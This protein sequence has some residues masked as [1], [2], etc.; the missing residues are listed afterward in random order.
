MKRPSIKRRIIHA[1]TISVLGSGAAIVLGMALNVLIARAWKKPELMGEY[2]AFKMFLSLFGTIAVLS[3]PRAVLKFTAEYEEQGR[4]DRVRALFSTVFLFL[5]LTCVLIA[6]VSLVFSPLLGNLIHLRV[7]GP[8]AL[9]LGATLLLATYSLLSSTLFLGLLQNV[10]GFVISISSLLAM[11][12]LAVWAYLVRPFPVYLLLVA[13]YLISGLLGLF[14]VRRQGLLALRFDR[15]ELRRAFAFALPLVLVSGMDFLVEWSDR[16]SLGAYFGP[17]EIGLFSA[18]LFVFSAARRLPLSLTEVLVPS[19]SKISVSGKEVLSRAFAKNIVFYGV[20]FFFLTLSIFLYR[21]EIIALLYPEEY[22][23]AASVLGIIS[24]AFIFSAV[25]NPGSSLLIG[26]GYTKLNSI[27]YAIGVGVF[28]PSVFVFTRLWGTTG[29]ATA[30]LL[31]QVV[32]TAGMLIILKTKIRL[33]IDLRPLGRLAVFAAA[34]GGLMLLLRRLTPSLGA[35]LPIL[36]ILYF[37]GVWL[38]VLSEEDKDYLRDILRQARQGRGMFKE[39][40]VEWENK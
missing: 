12:G 20:I 30:K 10:R 27:N 40:G 3:L 32:T 4:P 21:R 37:G 29:A 22:A 25:A 7:D 17:R 19:Y 26:S 1:G 38:I 28:V 31:T 36:A 11:T 13:G 34:V 6:L 35:G 39:P 8:K 23:A 24:W 9:L 15:G 16:I 18:G 14:L 2:T 33:R 5:T